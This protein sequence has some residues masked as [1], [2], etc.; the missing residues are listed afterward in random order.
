LRSQRAELESL[1]KDYQLQVASSD[2]QTD[3]FEPIKARSVRMEIAAT[4]NAAAA[5][6]YEFQVWTVEA[7]NLGTKN[8]ALASA[9]AVPSASSFELA[10]QTRHFDNLV[11]G[12]SDRRQAFPWVAATPGPAWLQIDLQQPTMID[13]V[14]WDRGGKGVPSDYVIKVLPVGEEQWQVVASTSSR[15][16]REDDL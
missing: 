11:D 4:T 8:I 9:G 13:R 5:S 14:V 10:N 2:I 16:P 7:N 1:R 12:S 3:M 6:L 15:L